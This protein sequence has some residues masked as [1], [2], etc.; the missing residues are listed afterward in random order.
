VKQF[1]KGPWIVGGLAVYCFTAYG[2][3]LYR[4][5]SRSAEESSKLQIP[6]DVLDRYDRTARDYDN[7]V[8]FAE[9]AMW[10][11]RLRNS[12]AKRAYGDVLE[13]SVGTG[14]NIKYYDIEKCKSIT[15]VD[16]SGEM[17]KIATEKLKGIAQRLQ[18]YLKTID[19]GLSS[20]WLADERL[21]SFTHN[22]KTAL[23]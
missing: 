9:K 4:V 18:G 5:Y 1:R 8:D 22:T 19:Y 17:V 6:E 12:L 20:Q 21:Q 10:L 13:V 2:F 15:M 11:G 16:Q 3:F 23:S 7:E 14:R